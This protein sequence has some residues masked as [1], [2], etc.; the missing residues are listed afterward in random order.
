MEM[1]DYLRRDIQE[2]AEPFSCQLKP[3]REQ[4]L[5]ASAL[6][7]VMEMRLRNSR[8]TWYL[9]AFFTLVAGAD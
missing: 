8:Y 4:P 9:R 5:G 6:N 1:E 2:I 7:L 3:I